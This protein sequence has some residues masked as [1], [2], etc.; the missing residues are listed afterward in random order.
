MSALLQIKLAEEC[1]LD[2]NYLII[3]LNWIDSVTGSAA[4]Q[5]AS[6]GRAE[7]ALVSLVHGPGR[8]WSITLCSRWILRRKKRPTPDTWCLFSEITSEVN[9]SSLGKG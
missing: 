9:H 8:D 1:G 3:T 2:L 5:K 6:P 4:P 7:L